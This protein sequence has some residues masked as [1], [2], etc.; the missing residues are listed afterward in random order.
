[1]KSKLYIE[2]RVYLPENSNQ[3]LV[4]EI[5]EIYKDQ[6]YDDFVKEEC[7]ISCTD[8]TYEVI[9]EVEKDNK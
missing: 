2:Y 9:R 8:V 4:H 6:L 1:M 3:E 7:G 5:A